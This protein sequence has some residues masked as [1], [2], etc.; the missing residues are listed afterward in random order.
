MTKKILKIVGVFFLFL[1]VALFTI[2]YFFKD[3][4]KTKIEAAINEK[5]DAKISFADADLSLFRNFPSAS[6]SVKKLVIIN[7]APFE[8]DTLFSFEE[9]NLKM[10][11]KELFHGDSEPLTIDGISSKN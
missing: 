9:L 4:I 8:V 5:V 6:V 11:I 10:S 2:P 1:L 3:K 7:K